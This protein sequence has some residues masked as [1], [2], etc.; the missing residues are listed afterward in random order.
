MIDGR[1]SN[2]TMPN[3]NVHQCWTRQ[4]EP[5]LIQVGKQFGKTCGAG[6]GSIQTPGYHGFLGTNGAAPGEFT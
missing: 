1:A 2:C 4:G 3:D 6:G 5:P